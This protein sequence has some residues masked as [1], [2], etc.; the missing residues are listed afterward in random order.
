M[1]NII[2][3]LFPYFLFPSSLFCLL[4]LHFSFSFLFFLFFVPLF[5]S[6][7]LFPL[8]V[9]LQSS[10]PVHRHSIA[11][12]PSFSPKRG[13][14]ITGAGNGAG[15]CAT[16]NGDLVSAKAGDDDLGSA[17]AGD[18]SSSGAT[19]ASDSGTRLV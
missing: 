15:C 10:Y 2:H 9:L 17:A 13:A 18:G 4:F 1:K 6:L 5:F 16:G 12:S 8:P 14:S 11:S 7:F 19:T 3:F